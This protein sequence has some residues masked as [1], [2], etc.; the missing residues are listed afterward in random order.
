VVPLPMSDPAAVDPEE[1]FVAS[2]STCHMLWFLSIA[3]KRKFSVDQYVDCAV[4]VMARNAQG[5]MAMTT[6][7]LKP[8][9]RFSGSVQPT[10]AEIVAMHHEA[11][12]E[13]FIA[14]SVKTQVD[15]EPVFAPPT[16]AG[17]RHATAGGV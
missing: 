1:A 16:D 5:K 6:V 7:T 17:N 14:N 2:L 11:H 12:D 3:Q 15:C 4:G 10:Q 9:V 8:D 13:C